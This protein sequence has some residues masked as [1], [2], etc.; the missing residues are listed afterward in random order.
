[1]EDANAGGSVSTGA[2][3]APSVS[4]SSTV[5]P[6]PAPSASEA[7]STQAPPQQS[8][9]SQATGAEPTP[10]SWTDSLS[11]DLKNYVDNK[12]FKDPGAVLESYIN[13]EKLRGVPQD[14]LLKMP[15]T[16]DDPQWA[17]VYS[18]LGKPDTPEGYGLSVPEG[19]DSTVMDWAK[20]AFHKNNLS[21]DQ[22]QNVIESFRQMAENQQSAELEAYNQ[23][24]QKQEM[25]LKKEWGQAY[26][27]NIANAQ[28]AVKEFGLPSEAIDAMEKAIG[29]DGVM[30]FMNS[31]GE[32]IGEGKYHAGTGDGQ[33]FGNGV[34]TPERARAEINKLKQDNTFVQKWQAGDI[35][36]RRKMEELH[37]MAYDI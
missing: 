26:H 19:E 20:D 21:V 18:K 8:A 15:E 17:E 3:S 29:F 4:A 34:L 9:A 16:S 12:G 10:A 37:Q 28:A 14:R 1:M 11:A 7:V 30:K 22:A 13:L 24:L 27:Q 23:G 36:S 35:D 33:G 5:N 25:D 6:A 2:E 32:R 31:I